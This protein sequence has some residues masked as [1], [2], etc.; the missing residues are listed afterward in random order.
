MTLPF[1]EQVVNE[2][3]TFV[4]IKNSESD[5]I[6]QNKLECTI[7]DIENNCYYTISSYNE[8]A[9]WVLFNCLHLLSIRATYLQ[10]TLTGFKTSEETGMLRFC[11]SPDDSGKQYNPTCQCVDEFDEPPY[12]VYDAKK[13][14]Y[15]IE[16]SSKLKKYIKNIFENR[17]NCL[18]LIE[19]LMYIDKEYK[20]FYPLNDYIDYILQRM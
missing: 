6:T 7:N 2:A 1:I 15:Y 13:A 8:K 12:F 3:L 10:W 20:F 5:D 16:H 14:K 19:V 17:Q 4:N 18:Q 9:L 11:G